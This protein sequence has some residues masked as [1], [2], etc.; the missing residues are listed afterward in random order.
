MD[1]GRSKELVMKAN[2]IPPAHQE[3]EG[4]ARTSARRP[5]VRTATKEQ[6][7][8]AQRKTSEVHAGLFRRLAK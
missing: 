7:E 8:K 2:R 5:K 1:S 3:A 6:F 4:E